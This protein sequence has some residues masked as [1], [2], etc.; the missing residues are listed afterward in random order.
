MFTVQDIVKLDG[1]QRK[2]LGGYASASAVPP[3]HS[4]VCYAV[5]RGYPR[6]SMCIVPILDRNYGTTPWQPDSSIMSASRRRSQ[7]RVQCTKHHGF[8][9]GRFSRKPWLQCRFKNR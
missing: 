7:N 2:A 8:G 3:V 4:C 5:S 6:E 1:S 9:S